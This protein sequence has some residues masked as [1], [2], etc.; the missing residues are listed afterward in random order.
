M[1]NLHT[2]KYKETEIL[3]LLS[4]ALLQKQTNLILSAT[5]ESEVESWR[6]FN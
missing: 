1:L 4:F 2:R 5:F 3:F 6:Q